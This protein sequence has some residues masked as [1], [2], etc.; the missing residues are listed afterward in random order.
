MPDLTNTERKFIH[1]L[2]MQLGLKSKSYGKGEDRRITVSKPK[3]SKKIAGQSLG[4]DNEV[5]GDSILPSLNV[6]PSGTKA[7]RCHLLKHPPTSI[8]EAESLLT[9][10]SIVNSMIT[11]V[12][13]RGDAEHT[14]SDG[15]KDAADSALLEALD[16]LNLRGSKTES[17]RRSS[18]RVGVDISR[19]IRRHEAAQKA[20]LVHPNF[21][22]MLKQRRALPAY[23]FSKKICD[24]IYNNRVTVLSG[25]TGCGKSTQVPQFLLDDERIGPKA[26]IVITQPRRISAISVAERV[27]SERCEMAGGMVGYNVR[28]EGAST[29]DTQ[30]LFVTPGVLLRRLQ[31]SPDLVE[32]N[33]VIMDEVHERDKNTDFLMIALRELM[34]RKKDLRIVLMSATIQTNELM[35]YWSGIGDS[36]VVNYDTMTDSGVMAFESSMPAEI[37]IP[38]RTFPVQEFFLEDVLAMTG[39]VD[40]SSAMFSSDMGRIE[41]ELSALLQKEKMDGPPQRRNK[42]KEKANANTATPSLSGDGSIL[43]CVMCGKS[44]FR[45][46]EELGEHVAMCDGGGGVTM[47]ELEEKVRGIDIS[48][49]V[50]YDK[51]TEEAPTEKEDLA[52]TEKE[53]LLLNSPPSHFPWTNPGS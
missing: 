47:E 1:S 26:S 4:D 53:D 39:F 34:S 12:G 40:D 18:P 16:E 15:D 49:V 37:S 6:G 2:S 25:D 22:K 10:S 5:A 46:P 41:S 33:I 7:L 38:G 17:V 27:A 23:N 50:R 48:A 28:L 44:D 30:L 45:R 9:G 19:R 42:N 11:N 21:P 31:S 13:K 35:S 51:V 3:E 52:P 24:T 29:K 20:K 36:E 8:E 14:R 43:T 32:F